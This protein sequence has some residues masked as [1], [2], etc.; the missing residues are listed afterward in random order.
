ML[1]LTPQ[2]TARPVFTT[3]RVHSGKLVRALLWLGLIGFSVRIVVFMRMR[4][5]SEFASVDVLAFVQICI[6]AFLCTLLPMSSRI[7]PVVRSLPSSS[8]GLLLA[9][10][11]L[12]AASAAW[13]PIPEYSFYKAVEVI[14]LI[15]AI[16][17]ALSYSRDFYSAELTTLLICLLALILAIV[18]WAKLRNWNL[19]SDSGTSAS[20]VMIVCYCVGEFN[21]AVKW[22]RRIL[23]VSVLIALMYLLAVGSGENTA[24]MIAMTCGVVVI[25][26]V[27]RRRRYILVPTLIGLIFASFW[28]QSFVHEMY[29][30]GKTDETIQSLSGRI[31]L[32]QEFIEVVAPSPLYGQGF[33]VTARLSGRSSTH[34]GLLAVFTGTGALGLIIVTL[35]LVRLSKEFWNSIRT[36]QPGAVGCAAA[37]TAGL[38]NCFTVPIIG[39]HWRPESLVFTC[40]FALHLFVRRPP[41]R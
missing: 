13:S 10:Y 22:R 31:P 9:Y 1:Q 19:L 40:F 29:F 32:W 3:D 39:E 23:F 8:G 11:L 34:S 30:G 27:S 41:V 14:V 12:C 6:I 5:A 26:F 35:G 17:V 7:G 20:A 15:L 25:A 24:S 18:G 28:S 16:F 21:S 37:L 2:I 36:H 4:D 33:A 38:V